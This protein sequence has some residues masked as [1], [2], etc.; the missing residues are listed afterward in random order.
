MP[1]GLDEALDELKSVELIRQ[2]AWTSRSSRT[3]CEHTLTHEVTYATLLDERRR[4]PPASPQAIEDVETLAHHWTIAEDWPRALDYL[5]RAADDAAAEFDDVAVNFYEQ[6]IV[7][8]DRLDD[9]PRSV[10]LLARD[11]D[12][13]MAAGK[14]AEAAE[15]RAH[16][17]ESEPRTPPRRWAWAPRIGASAPIC[18]RTMS[19]G[20]PCLVAAVA[21]NDASATPP[22]LRQPR[23]WKLVPAIFATTDR[24]G[25]EV[26]SGH[27]GAEGRGNR[28]PTRTVAWIQ[29]FGGA[30][31][32]WQG[33]LRRCLGDGPKPPSTADLLT[34]PG[35]SG[36]EAS[37]RPRRAGSTK[38]A[39]RRSSTPTRS[40]ACNE[41]I[42]RARPPTPSAGCGSNSGDLAEHHG[43]ERA[44]R[45]LPA[46]GRRPRR[47]DR[48]KHA[49]E[50]DGGASRHRAGPRRLRPG[51]GHHPWSPI[52]GT[53]LLWRFTQ[54]RLLLKSPVA[55]GAGRVSTPTAA[56]P[57]RR[58]RGGEPQREVP[59][60]GGPPLWGDSALASGSLDAAEHE[61]HR[62]R[63]TSSPAVT[64]EQ[65]R[66]LALLAGIAATRGDADPRERR[67]R[68]RGASPRPPRR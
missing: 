54:R 56:S 5:E 37:P 44:V 55:T 52:Q 6:A 4:T 18:T 3:C 66:S 26:N 57:T 20:E 49:A 31:P 60:E 2:K 62:S 43:V 50:P 48:V 40:V 38:G 36:C 47:G 12:A 16:G 27:R 28:R 13:S 33:D 30:V 9:L 1:D 53:W 42:F 17:R 51:R 58:P 41:T 29:S 8:V 65:W 46:R 39:P 22:A 11:G 34:T 59:G 35:T 63:W 14:L 19:S 45:R 68:K 24:V 61:A 67:R 10:S 21:T 15:V 32:R 7:I 25:S 23:S 64:P